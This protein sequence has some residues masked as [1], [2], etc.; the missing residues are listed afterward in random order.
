MPEIPVTRRLRAV[1]DNTP[2]VSTVILT[3]GRK[4]PW[5]SNSFR[6]A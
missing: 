4:Q 3:N 6:K 5:Q 1:S 2:R